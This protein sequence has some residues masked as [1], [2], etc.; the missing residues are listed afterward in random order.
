M[1]T[2]NFENIKNPEEFEAFRK[3]FNQGL[4]KDEIQ[5]II[6]NPNMDAINDPDNPWKKVK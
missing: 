3:K 1:T 5:Q 4:S 2:P 6:D